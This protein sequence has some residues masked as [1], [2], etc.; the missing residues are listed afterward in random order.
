MN[1]GKNSGNV[2]FY[3]ALVRRVLKNG[4]CYEKIAYDGTFLTK[5]KNRH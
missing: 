4:D 5:L 3:F 1:G 2:V